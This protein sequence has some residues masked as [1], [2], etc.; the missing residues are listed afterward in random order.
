MSADYDVGGRQVV[1][2]GLHRRRSV[3]VRIARR[4]NSW[5]GRPLD[6][7]P[8]GLALEVEKAVPD[9]DVGEP[10]RVQGAAGVRAVAAGAPGQGERGLNRETRT[11]TATR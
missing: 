5:P 11:T 1:G 4:E 3:I 10:T 6:N 7:D 8:V 9:P 2:T